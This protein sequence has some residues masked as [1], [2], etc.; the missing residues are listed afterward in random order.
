MT[1][2]LETLYGYDQP[3]L[4]KDSTINLNNGWCDKER[5]SLFSRGVPSADPNFL[6][7]KLEPTE[8][9]SGNQKRGALFEYRDSSLRAGKDKRVYY[10]SDLYPWLVGAHSYKHLAHMPSTVTLLE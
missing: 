7:H 10:K 6:D 8:W 1:L 4:A 3:N 9:M 5:C 2:L